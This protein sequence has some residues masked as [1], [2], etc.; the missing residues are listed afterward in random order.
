METLSDLDSPP[1][2]VNLPLTDELVDIWR[3]VL[4]SYEQPTTVPPR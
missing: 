1:E 2:V 3:D 4:R